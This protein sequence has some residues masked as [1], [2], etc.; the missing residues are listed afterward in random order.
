M[1]YIFAPGCALILYKPHLMEKLHEFL[2]SRYGAMEVL[3]TVAQVVVFLYDE[4]HR[5]GTP[6]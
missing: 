6:K 1:K 5:N 3:L 4:R 2:N